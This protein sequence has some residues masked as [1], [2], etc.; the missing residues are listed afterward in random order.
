[1]IEKTKISGFLH[2]RTD[3]GDGVRTGV[4][5]S[6]CRENCSKICLPYDF[7]QTF[8]ELQVDRKVDLFY[9]YSDKY[10]Q[11]LLARLL[12]LRKALWKQLMLG[13]QTCLVPTAQRD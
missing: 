5:F 10:L 1:M 4:V 8:G 13:S 7:L 2:Y 9:V 12:I 11:T 6:F 3:L